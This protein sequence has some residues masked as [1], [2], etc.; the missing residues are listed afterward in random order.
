[1][2]DATSHAGKIDIGKVIA[3]TFGVLRRNLAT[4]TVLSLLL[5]GLPTALITYFHLDA[6]GGEVVNF[7][8]TDLL[9]TLYAVLVAL[10]ASSVLQ[11]ALMYATVQDMNGRRPAI[12]EVLGT[13]LRAFLPIIGFTILLMIALVF[14][15]VLLIVPGIIMLCVWAVAIPALV[16]ERTGIIAAF[17]RSAE[18][19]RGNRWSIFALGLLVVIA[20]MIFSGILS[21]LA[22]INLLSNDPADIARPANIAVQAITQTITALVSATGVAVLYVELRKAREGRG[23]EWLSEI[24]S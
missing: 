23:P 4:F 16:A 7:E 18:L 6:I 9:W 24:Y 13:G 5:T 17:S 15:F 22:G 14:G 19:T 1:M 20:S 11:G 3:D 12:V 2:T 10:F 21:A 8:A